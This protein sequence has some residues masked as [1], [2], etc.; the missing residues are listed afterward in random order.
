MQIFCSQFLPNRMLSLWSLP[1]MQSWPGFI[2]LVKCHLSA[3][4]PCRRLH[5]HITTWHH[6]SVGCR[7]NSSRKGD[8]RCDGTSK[9]SNFSFLKCILFE[10]FLFKDLIINQRDST[11]SK[12]NSVVI[13]NDNNFISIFTL[14]WR[15]VE[16]EILR[17]WKF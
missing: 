9:M 4:S 2:S 3:R 5:W 12:L 10:V 1:I 17:Q 11:I 6:T 15:N 8:M 7:G 13:I 16:L 14:S